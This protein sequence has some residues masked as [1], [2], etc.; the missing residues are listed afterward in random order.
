MWA[1]VVNPSAM[2]HAVFLGHDNRMCSNTRSYRALP[3]RPLDDQ[4]LGELMLSH[5]PA[6]GEAAYA[7]GPAASNGAFHLRYDGTTGVTLSDEPQLLAVN[8]V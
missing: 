5:H 7:V 2:Q 1:S 4:V 3:P 6:T 8:S